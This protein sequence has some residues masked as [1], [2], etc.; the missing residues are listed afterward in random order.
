L[1]YT[2]QQKTFPY[3][4][5]DFSCWIVTDKD[6]CFLNEVLKDSW[7]F[8]LGNRYKDTFINSTAYYSLEIDQYLPNF[9]WSNNDKP[10]PVCSVK[11]VTI[12][13][14]SFQ[15]A[16]E[17]DLSIENNTVSF[18][19]NQQTFKHKENLKYMTHE[20]T[21]QYKDSLDASVKRPYSINDKHC[22]R[23][24]SQVQCFLKLLPLMP[25]FSGIWIS[26]FIYDPAN[27]ELL[28]YMKNPYPVEGV[29]GDKKKVHQKKVEMV[30]DKGQKT[31]IKF[32]YVQSMLIKRYKKIDENKTEIT[33]VY[34]KILK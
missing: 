15:K 10:T 12:V 19:I 32:V 34:S 22:K 9:N 14:L 8:V 27:E 30:F 33:M 5:K 24:T 18:T 4:K 23:S 16:Y 6:I 29:I 1:V 17:A 20:E 13:N 21:M 7:N 3:S 26:S 11:T 28:M 25:Y 31:S 2:L